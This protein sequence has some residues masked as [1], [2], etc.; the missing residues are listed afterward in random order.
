MSNY[1]NPSMVIQGHNL[2]KISRSRSTSELNSLFNLSFLT[3]D[4]WLLN[5]PKIAENITGKKVTGKQISY[6]AMLNNNS[7]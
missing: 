2:D 3:C 5:L 4:E 1:Q 7:D 6:A